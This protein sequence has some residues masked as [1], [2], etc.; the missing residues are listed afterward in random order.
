MI[1][2]TLF[3]ILVLPLVY[4]LKKAKCSN[5][6]FRSL[7]CDHS[8][9]KEK[10]EIF[11]K[12]TSQKQSNNLKSTDLKIGKSLASTNVYDGCPLDKNE[13]GKST[14]N[15]LHTIAAS[16]PDDPTEEFK[17][18]TMQFIY[19]LSILYPCTYCAVDF[20]DS[21]QLS[22]PRLLLLL[23][24]L[25]III[26]IIHFL[27]ILINNLS[28]IYFYCFKNNKLGENKKIGKPRTIFVVVL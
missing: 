19:S 12:F 27:Y 17:I 20:R 11:R 5:E 25:S 24:L 16:Y 26:I 10:M 18:I 14:W 13:L 8:A 1:K 3:P 2:S 21:I 7:P 9:C 6:K 23:L 4:R 15:L 22:P 28:Y